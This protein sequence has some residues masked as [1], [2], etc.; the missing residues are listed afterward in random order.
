MESSSGRSENKKHNKI[1]KNH[2]D[3][4]V[5]AHTFD[6]LLGDEHTFKSS[7]AS[8]FFYFSGSLPE[9]E[10]WRDGGTEHG[11]NASKIGTVNI[12]PGNEGVGNDFSEGKIGEEGRSNVGKDR[13]GEPA[14]ERRKAFIGEEDE[15]EKNE[16]GENDGEDKFRK[17]NEEIEGGGHTG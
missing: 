8:L 17:R 2:T 1:T 16:E 6:F 15:T 10:V 4:D 11:D 12:E 13:Q 7:L 9:K 5:L 3:N 14:E